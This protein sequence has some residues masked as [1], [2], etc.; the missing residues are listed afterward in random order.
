MKIC[1]FQ[2]GFLLFSS[3]VV[4]SKE[5]KKISRSYAIGSVVSVLT[6]YLGDLSSSR[7]DALNFIKKTVYYYLIC[8]ILKNY[9]AV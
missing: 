4:A 1:H 7:T 6:L 9:L 5:G 8:Q 3:L 2:I